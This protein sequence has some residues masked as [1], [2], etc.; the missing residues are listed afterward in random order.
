MTAG[1]DGK[2]RATRLG[3]FHGL[4][5]ILKDFRLEKPNFPC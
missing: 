3:F 5:P 2:L 4:K 1:P